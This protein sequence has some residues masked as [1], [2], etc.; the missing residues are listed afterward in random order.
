MRL[1][2]RIVP[3]HVI[4]SEAKDLGSVP[5]PPYFPKGIANTR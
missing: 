5:A 2:L 3:N 1:R 4:L